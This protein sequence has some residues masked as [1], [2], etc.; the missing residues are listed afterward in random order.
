MLNDHNIQNWPVFFFKRCRFP[1]VE[2]TKPNV[3]DR[4]LSKSKAASVNTVG[5]IKD[6]EHQGG[7]E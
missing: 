3:F 6:P 7:D 5:G 1:I 4:E 2:K